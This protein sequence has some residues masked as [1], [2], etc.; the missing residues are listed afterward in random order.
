MVVCFM[1]CMNQRLFMERTLLA[2]HPVGR[3]NVTQLK[4]LPGGFHPRK[5]KAYA[6]FDARAM[7]KEKVCCDATGISN[8]VLRRCEEWFKD[9]VGERQVV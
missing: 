7:F 2:V 3:L 9:K 4:A 6:R 1:K 8:L 5:Q